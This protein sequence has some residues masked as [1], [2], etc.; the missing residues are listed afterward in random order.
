MKL[1]VLSRLIKNET[2]LTYTLREVEG[3]GSLPESEIPDYRKTPGTI[4]LDIN[5]RGQFATA[6]RD[7]YKVY[8]AAF[9]ILHPF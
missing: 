1:R 6:M 8:E 3:Y 2:L 9:V 5:F 4:L 7:T